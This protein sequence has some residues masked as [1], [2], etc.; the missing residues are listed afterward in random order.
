MWQMLCTRLYGTVANALGP[1]RLKTTG[2]HYRHFWQK[3]LLEYVAMDI[4][5]PL[6]KTL[7]GS[8]FLFMM[9]GHVFEV[10]ESHN[11]V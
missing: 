1:S 2:V 6:L 10:N 7:N 11:D 5:G 8:H 4:L 9:T 3:D